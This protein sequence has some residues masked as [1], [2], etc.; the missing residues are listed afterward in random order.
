MRSYSEIESEIKPQSEMF[1][2]VWGR[3]RETSDLNTIGKKRHF[4]K[5]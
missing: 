5:G 1:R 2:F 4:E 3:K